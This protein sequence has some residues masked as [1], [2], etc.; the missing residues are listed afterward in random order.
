MC[1]FF[2]NFTIYL[3]ASLKLLLGFNNTHL[4]SPHS[5]KVLSCS[6]IDEFDISLHDS[7]HHGTMQFIVIKLIFL[8]VFL[9]LGIFWD[10]SCNPQQQQK[11]VKHPPA[12]IYQNCTVICIMDI[13]KM[14]NH[15]F[16]CQLF[17]WFCIHIESQGFHNLVNPNSTQPLRYKLSKT[18]FHQDYCRLLCKTSLWY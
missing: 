5:I 18:S 14:E 4:T 2:I 16:H 8:L 10:T 9:N 7:H 12:W 1:F 17:L 11:C 6:T 13:S 3:I 15:K